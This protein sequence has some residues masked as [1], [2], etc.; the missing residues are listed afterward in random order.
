MNHTKQLFKEALAATPPDVKQRVDWSFEVA[1]RIADILQQRGMSQR[2]LSKLVGCTEA[3]VSRWV[4]GTHNFT[5]GTLARISSA[6]GEPLISV[7]R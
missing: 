4:G 1:D 3:E 7:V 6:L 2:D 5:L